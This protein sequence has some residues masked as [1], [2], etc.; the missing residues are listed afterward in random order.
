[1]KKW[2]TSMCLAVTLLAGF[3]SAGSASDLSTYAVKEEPQQ[4]LPN[5]H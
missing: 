5:Q 2:L 3:S 1:M 4:R